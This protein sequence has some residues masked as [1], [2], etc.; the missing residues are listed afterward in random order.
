MRGKRRCEDVTSAA[1]RDSPAR[2][3]RSDRVREPREGNDA[4]TLSVRHAYPRAMR[5]ESG[6][7]HRQPDNLGVPQTRTTQDNVIARLDRAI[8]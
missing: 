7:T 8:Q 1:S 6:P 2:R 4:G 3:P 5:K